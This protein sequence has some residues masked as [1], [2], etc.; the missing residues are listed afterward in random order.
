MPSISWMLDMGCFGPL[1]QALNEGV[2]EESICRDKT[3][4]ADWRM[5]ESQNTRCN[6]T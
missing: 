6:Y 5:T 4:A 3:S 2:A 1:N